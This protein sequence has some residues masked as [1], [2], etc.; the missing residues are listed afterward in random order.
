VSY[1]TGLSLFQSKD[2]GRRVPRWETGAE[3]GAS[4]SMTPTPE[5]P[6]PRPMRVRTLFRESKRDL[7]LGPVTRMDR[8]PDRTAGDQSS[9]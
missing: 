3:I 2:N 1:R 9:R 4:S 7:L 8:E 6:N 5:S